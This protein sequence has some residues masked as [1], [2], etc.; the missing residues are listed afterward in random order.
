MQTTLAKAATTNE[1]TSWSDER[2]VEECLRGSE[3]AWDALIDKYKVLI[4]SVPVRFGLTPDESTDVFQEVCVSLL[5]ELETLRQPRALPSWLTHTAWHKCLHHI[6]RNRRYVEWDDDGFGSALNDDQPL[7]E[8]SLQKL[9]NE[10][11]LR[12]A[13]TE[14]P[15]RCESL[16]RMLFY[17]QPP[18]PYH[19]VA[20]RLGLAKGSIG[21]TRMRCLD[22]LR[23]RLERKGFS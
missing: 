23:E 10:Q 15:A 6:R 17:E 8:A 14:L 11:T 20:E 9:E 21:F 22:R 18:V 5:S 4:Y 16:I 19:E 3:A 1:K 12:E 13:I 7:A 2:L